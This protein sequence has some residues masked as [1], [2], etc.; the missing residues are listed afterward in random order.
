MQIQIAFCN[1]AF[2]PFPSPLICSIGI[3]ARRRNGGQQSAIYKKL[4][5]NDDNDDD[6]NEGIYI[7]GNDIDGDGIDGDDMLVYLKIG[8]HCTM[9]R[10]TILMIKIKMIFLGKI[11]AVVMTM[12]VALIMGMGMMVVGLMMMMSKPESRYLDKWG[13]VGAWHVFL[14]QACS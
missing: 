5:S 4:S 13:G 9:I 12:L 10:L 14:R 11:L 6:D 7:D 2:S 8:I 3:C 1:S